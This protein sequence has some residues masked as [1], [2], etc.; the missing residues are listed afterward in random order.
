MMD[1]RVEANKI[2][3]GG[4]RDEHDLEAVARACDLMYGGRSDIHDVQGALSRSL[5]PGMCYKTAARITEAAVVGSGKHCLLSQ[6]WQNRSS[7][8]HF[9]FCLGLFRGLLNLIELG[10]GFHSLKDEE[11]L[12]GNL[13]EVVSKQVFDS[14]GYNSPAK[15]E[16]QE[17]DGQVGQAIKGLAKDANGRALIVDG[18]HLASQNKSPQGEIICDEMGLMVLDQMSYALYGAMGLLDRL[19]LFS[20]GL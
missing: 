13:P 8:T 5:F 1:R 12:F 6:L 19:R 20:P 9:G 14:Y 11:P 4:S 15:T 2:L 18:I 16:L 3:V 17:W 7:H 10:V